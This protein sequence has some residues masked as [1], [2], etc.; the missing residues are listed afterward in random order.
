M[1]ETSHEQEGRTHGILRN[2]LRHISDISSCAIS[3]SPSKLKEWNTVHGEL[4]AAET[5]ICEVFDMISYLP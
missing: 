1:C 4:V 2:E 5:T 3:N